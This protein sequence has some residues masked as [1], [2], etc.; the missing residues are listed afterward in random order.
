MA[1]FDPYAELLAIV[2]G[3]A[4]H[5][6]PYAL[7][8]AV[9]LAI[10]GHPRATKD[11]DLLVPESCIDAAKTV[12]RGLGY[13]LEAAPMGFEGGIGVHR[14]SRVEERQLFTVDLLTAVGPLRE[15]WEDR[16]EARWQ[17]VA[18][19]AVSRAGLITMKRLAKRARDLADL[20]AL[21]AGDDEG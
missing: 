7:C 21:G 12:L 15:V 9:A 1:T 19:S 11:V 16:I 13:T 17:G 18:I 20:E 6:V 4:G 8:G 5:G 14:V 2:K 3:F 10:H